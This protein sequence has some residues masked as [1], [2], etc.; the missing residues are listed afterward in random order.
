MRHRGSLVCPSRRPTSDNLFGDL[1]QD[2]HPEA[3][4]PLWA[5]LARSP[6]FWIVCLISLGVTLLRETF[7]NWT[8]TYLV[9]VVGLGKGDAATNELAVS[10]LWW[11]FGIAGGHPWRPFRPWHARAVIIYRDVTLRPDAGCTWLERLR[12][13]IARGTYP[14]LARGVLADRAVFLSGRSDLPR[15]RRQAWRCD[16]LRH[17]RWHRLLIRRCDSR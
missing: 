13:T 8:P 2:P 12:G 1:G 11:R 10:I 5:T 15:L 17:Y 16:S 14:C 7:N 4:G 3:A 9:E 6:A